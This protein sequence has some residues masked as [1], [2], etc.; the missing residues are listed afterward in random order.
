MF[1]GVYCTLKSNNN[2]RM[3]HIVYILRNIVNISCGLQYRSR[4]LDQGNNFKQVK[5]SQ[6]IH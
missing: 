4:G 1:R 5:S 3:N 6:Q 2:M